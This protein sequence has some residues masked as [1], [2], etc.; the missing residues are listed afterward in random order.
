MGLKYFFKPF[1]VHKAE[2]YLIMTYCISGNFTLKVE[3][4]HVTLSRSFTKNDTESLDFIL[5]IIYYYYHFSL[6]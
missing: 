4:I 5:P 1:I 3:P 6:I 2:I